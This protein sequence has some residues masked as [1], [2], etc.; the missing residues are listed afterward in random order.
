MIIC[1]YCSTKWRTTR[2]KL[3]E[4]SDKNVEELL[5][6]EI[7]DQEEEMLDL[8]GTELKI[9]N[10]L[11]KNVQLKK[12]IKGSCQKHPEGGTAKILGGGYIPILAFL[13]TSGG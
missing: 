9:D 1:H 12:R 6:V 5:I 4:D 11:N 7:N 3:D 8:D 2:K 10:E 13:R